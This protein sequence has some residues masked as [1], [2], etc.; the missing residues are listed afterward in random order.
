MSYI[1][2][3]ISL[4]NKRPNNMD[5]L[6]L[7]G[8]YIEGK[9][10]LLAVVC[11]GVGSLENGLFASTT[12]TK[13]LSGWFDTT[14]NIN[15]IGI[16]M[17]D[18]VLEINSHIISEAQHADIHTASTLSALLL[19]ED[20]FYI[21]HIGDS[22]VY[23]SDGKTLTQITSDDVSASGKLT[24]CIGQSEKVIVKYYEGMAEGITFI[25]CTDGLYKRMDIDLMVAM[26]SASNKASRRALKKA[27][28]IL[29]LYVMKQGEQDNIT[30]ALVKGRN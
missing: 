8:K 27:I 5:S 2:Y 10:A 18:A 25:V 3:G 29:T 17:R 9:S 20:T 28:E 4:Q 13:M 12:S 23:S 11:D 24:A 7:K 26:M 1:F 21:V 15:C 6:L 14:E 16:N 30:I 22:R 19:I